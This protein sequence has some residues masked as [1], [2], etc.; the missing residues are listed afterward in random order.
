[1]PA[2]IPTNNRIIKKIGLVP[3]HL[4]MYQPIKIAT[5]TAA[6][7]SVLILK[8]DPIELLFFNNNIFF[9]I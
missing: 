2:T 1:M 7:N 4:S 8:A 9:I 6:T 3:N 5:N